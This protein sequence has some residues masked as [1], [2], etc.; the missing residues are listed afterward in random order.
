MSPKPSDQPKQIPLFDKL[1]REFGL[2]ND[3]AVAK[4]THTHLSVVSRTRYGVYQIGDAL[5]CRVARATGWSVAE[6]DALAKL[7]NR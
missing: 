2:I 7:S 3:T 6:I 1:M 5:I 4:F